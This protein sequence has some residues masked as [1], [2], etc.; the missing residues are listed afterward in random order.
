MNVNMR[1]GACVRIDVL[2]CDLVCE[3]YMNGSVWGVARVRND[4]L[5][6]DIFL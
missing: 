4:V 3:K 1:V 6:C 2:G 5:G